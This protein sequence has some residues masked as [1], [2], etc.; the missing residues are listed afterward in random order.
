MRLRYLDEAELTIEVVSVPCS[1]H[2]KAQTSDLR[3]F[4][5]CLYEEPSNPLP[6]E[7]LVDKNVAQPSEGCAIRHPPSESDLTACGRAATQGDRSLDRLGY[8]VHGPPR[9]PETLL[10]Q[11]F[12]DHH[13]VESFPIVADH[14]TIFPI[15]LHAATVD[16]TWRSHRPS[17]W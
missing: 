14:E 13:Q 7:R 15:P 11:P 8:Q 17:S 2:E 6:P 1:K 16:A 4:D 5:G 10:A 9:G 3:M 12:V